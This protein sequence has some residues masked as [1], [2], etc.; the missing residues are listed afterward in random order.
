[1]RIS[2]YVG[3]AVM[4][5]L[6]VIQTSVLPHFPIAGISPQLLFLVALAWGLLRGLEEGLVWAFIA[7]ICVDLFSTAPLGLSALAFMVAVAVGVLLQPLFPPRRLL[8]AFSLAAIGTVI[9]LSIYLIV[10]RL[11][12]HGMP[13]GSIA[14]LLPMLVLHALLIIPI[15]LLLQAILGPFRPRRHEY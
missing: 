7:G 11:L 6:A 10:L 5:V 12:G 15:Y 8:V 3:I 1:M 2:L 9:Y 14:G 4:I 13:A